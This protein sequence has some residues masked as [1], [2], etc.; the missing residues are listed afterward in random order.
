MSIVF[1]KRV[2]G[3][4]IFPENV[5]M[6]TIMETIRVDEVKVIRYV[7][8]KKKKKKLIIILKSVRIIWFN[9]HEEMKKRKKNVQIVRTIR[10]NKN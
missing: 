4:A 8:K 7:L 6:E 9:D 2:E 3:I 10:G 5:A 1:H